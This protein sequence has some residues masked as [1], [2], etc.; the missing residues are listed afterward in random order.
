MQDLVGKRIK[1]IKMDYTDPVPP[2]TEGKVKKID[3]LGLIHVH[4]FFDKKK[5]KPS[6]KGLCID[7][8][9]DTFK[10]LG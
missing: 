1:L 5:P 3:G 4:W 9:V 2:G 6:L 8:D 10:I 7:P